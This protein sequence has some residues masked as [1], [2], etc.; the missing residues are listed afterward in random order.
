MLDRNVIFAGVA[1]CRGGEGLLGPTARLRRRKQRLERIGR[2][3]DGYIGVALAVHVGDVRLLLVLHPNQRRREARDLRR[4]GDSERNRLP[5]EHDSIVVEWPERRSQR[6][7]VILVGLVV[8]GHL[9]AVRVR[10][11]LDHAFDL[12]RGGCVDA[13]DAAFRD[14]R[15]D[16]AAVK[17]TGRVELSG[18][19]CLAGDFRDAIDAGDASADVRCHDYP[20]TIFLDDC[21]CGVPRAACV[22]ARAMQRR[23]RSILKVLCAY[24]LASCSSKSAARAKV[25][26]LAGCPRSADSACGSRHGLCATPPSAKRPS[27]IVSPS[28]SSPTATETRPN[29]YESRSR[30]FRYV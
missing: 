10:K 30:I 20:Q 23:A 12:L 19:F 24:P 1:H 16:D 7:K 11:H 28:S 17:E 25:A 18:I 21:D 4:F 14:C 13:C 27:L 15:G 8:I 22:S 5:V 6:G 29:A 9:R 3:F 2:R 26:A